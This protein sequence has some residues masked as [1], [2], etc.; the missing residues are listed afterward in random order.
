MLYGGER[1]NVVRERKEVCDIQY[2]GAKDQVN[3]NI[4]QYIDVSKTLEYQI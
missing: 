1:I 3:V 2:K 4:C